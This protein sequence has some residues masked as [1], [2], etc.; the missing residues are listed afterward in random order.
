[1]AYSPKTGYLA[2]AD[3]NGK[4]YLWNTQ[5]FTIVESFPDPDSQ[6]LDSLAFSADG[7]LLATG[8]GNGNVYL[9]NVANDSLIATLYGL[10]GATVNSI[11]FSPRG[12]VLAATLNNKT[13]HTFEFC[14][15]NTAGKILDVRQDPDSTGGTQIIFSPDGNTLAVGD[16]NNYTY[17]WDA[18]GL[19]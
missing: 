12:G 6:G 11:G 2:V 14:V 16:G 3:G 1:V 18:S 8:D 10:K 5:D 4:T 13:T 9:W 7:S 19:Y 15:W 17:I